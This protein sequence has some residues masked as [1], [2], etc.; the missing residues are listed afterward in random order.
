MNA[1]LARLNGLIELMKTETI[2]GE[3]LIDKPVWRDRLM[4][5]QG[6][7]MA[8]R[9]NDLRVLSAR[10]N[11]A[12]ASLARMVVKLEGTELRHD[13]E[14]ASTPHEL[15]RDAPGVQHGVGHIEIRARDL[16]LIEDDV[17]KR[18]VGKRSREH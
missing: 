2:D 17:Y 7:V 10:L 6:R 9:F 3:R 15:R 5:I 16:I 4:K 8:L 1:T 11:K 13:L 12:D 18:Q 14:G